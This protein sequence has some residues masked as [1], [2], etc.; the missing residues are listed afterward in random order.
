MHTNAEQLHSRLKNLMG[1]VVGRY[2]EVS[3]EA[4]ANRYYVE[5][6][7]VALFA[8]AVFWDLQR[9]CRR[10]GADSRAD[11]AENTANSLGRIISVTLRKRKDA[12]AGQ[13]ATYL[14]DA[15]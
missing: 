4:R 15:G 13:A 10:T 8:A 3:P 11:L 2:C 7:F 9:V 1:D 6:R 12:G 14:A 5:R